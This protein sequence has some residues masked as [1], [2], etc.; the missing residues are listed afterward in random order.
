[1]TTNLTKAFKKLKVYPID[2]SLLVEVPST[3]H[4]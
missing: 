1:M 4:L 2:N 3:I